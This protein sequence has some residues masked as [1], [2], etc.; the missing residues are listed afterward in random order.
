M[1]AYGPPPPPPLPYPNQPPAPPPPELAERLGARVVRRPEPRFGVALAAVGVI[2]M[3]SGVIAWAG[4]YASSGG[5][6]ESPFGGG[7]GSDS[8]KILG[9]ALSL[10][11]VAA[12]YVV[13]ILRQSGPLTNAGVAASALGVPVLMGFLSYDPSSGGGLPFSVDAIAI[14]SML[15][16][17]ASYLV[18][19]VVRGHVFYMGTTLLTLWLYLLDKIEPHLFS[20]RWIFPFAFAD[21]IDS[22]SADF[23]APSFA[24]PDFGTVAGVCLV[25]GLGYYV[26]ALVLDSTGRSGLAV[27]F[28]LVGFLATGSG[29]AAAA[30]NLAQVVTGILL[31]V[32]GAAIGAYGARSRRRFTTWLSGGGIWFGIVL[33]LSKAFPH[34]ETEAGISL[35]IVGAVLVAVAPMWT[36]LLN[37]PDETVV[38]PRP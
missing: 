11:V 2:L 36:R 19:P 29:I 20:F 32:L 4:E 24:P 14:V 25:F 38:G 33:I 15:V 7:G 22:S 21:N 9:I 18:V 10:A 6:G 37:E 23:G 12:A 26:I 3:I 1:S 31:I 13:A 28:A 17:F 27:A 5:G 34:N 8:H 30:V 16:W 35:I